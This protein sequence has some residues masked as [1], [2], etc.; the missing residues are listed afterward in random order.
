MIWALLHVREV[1]K[2]VNGLVPQ[3]LLPA[4][5]FLPLLGGCALKTPGYTHSWQEVTEKA[6]CKPKRP[7]PHCHS[8]FPQVQEQHPCRT[9]VL[10][11][12]SR[13]S[14]ALPLHLSYASAPMSPSSRGFSK[15]RV[16][17]FWVISSMS[18]SPSYML[19]ITNLYDWFLP[20]NT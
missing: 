1:F 20:H 15:W 19:N 7:C 8:L 17:S 9:F 14:K 12:F 5:P 16:A 4:S 3:Q 18:I 13:C 6:S 2:Y 11:C 10:A